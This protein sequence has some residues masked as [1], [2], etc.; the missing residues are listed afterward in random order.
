[1]LGLKHDDL[2]YNF[3]NLWLSSAIDNTATFSRRYLN[4]KYTNHHG[5]STSKA[6]LP[7]ILPRPFTFTPP[8]FHPAS[9]SPRV[10][11][12]DSTPNALRTRPADIP[13]P[14]RP[15][16]LPTRGEDHIVG[17]TVLVKLGAASRTGRRAGEEQALS[18]VVEG[19]VSERGIWYWRGS[20]RGG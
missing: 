19:E 5:S 18:T 4:S 14:D 20:A 9:P 6:P 17:L 2:P 3:T 15:S 13:H 16:T 1:M 10:L 11:R 7:S 8:T 12:F